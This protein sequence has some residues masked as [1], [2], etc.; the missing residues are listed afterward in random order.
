MDPLSVAA[1][2]IG[3]VSSTQRT[4]SYVK[5]IYDDIG[6]HKPNRKMSQLM[7]T[8]SLVRSSFSLLETQRHLLTT[9]PALAYTTTTSATTSEDIFTTSRATI[10]MAIVMKDRLRRAMIAAGSDRKKSKLKLR[11]HSE[12]DVEDHKDVLHQLLQTELIPL[13]QKQEDLIALRHVGM[14]VS[15]MNT[16]H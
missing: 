9:S 4:L 6:T 13:I 7:T 5:H 8:A 16:V 12:E 3:V 1:G 2:V 14:N 11:A 10:A 15:A